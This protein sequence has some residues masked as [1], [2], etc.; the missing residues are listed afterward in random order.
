MITKTLNVGDYIFTASGKLGR[1]IKVNK[2]NYSYALI[3]APRNSWGAGNDKIPFNG[4]AN[5]YYG[6][7]EE[8]FVC[9]DS[10][11]KALELAKKKYDTVVSNEEILKRNQGLFGLAKYFLK[12]MEDIKEIDPRYSDQVPYDDED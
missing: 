4:I 8:W 5:H 9:D 12:Q 2:N 11:A 6:E 7:H 10:T 3:S 1:I